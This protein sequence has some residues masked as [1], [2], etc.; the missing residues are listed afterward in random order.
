MNELQEA[1]YWMALA[2]LPN[3]RTERINT[4]ITDILHNR[5][6]TLADFFQCT[7]QEWQQEFL[8]NSK[9]A[10]DLSE[11]KSNIPQL[12][13]LAEELFKKEF[14]LIPI[15]ARNYSE[16]LKHNLKLKYAPPL[17][18]VKGDPHV[19]QEPSAAIVG[20]RNASDVSLQ[21]TD[22]I[23][24]RCVENYQ[25]VVSGFA[26]GVDRTALESALKY[27]GKS[28]LVLPQGIL[29][30]T[31]GFKRY[32]EQILAGDVLVLS[33]FLPK[34]PW[35]VKFAMARNRYIYGLAEDIY[36]AESDSTGGTWSGAIDG[37]KK[38]RRVYVRKPGEKERNANNLL[39]QKGAISVDFEGNSLSSA[40][41]QPT[42]TKERTSDD[43]M[44]ETVEA[45]I[46][47]AL[48]RAS[49]PL[50]AKQ[51][52]DKLHL[53]VDT[54]KFSQ[55]LKNMEGITVVKQNNGLTFR[56]KSN[57]GLQEELF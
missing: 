43:K 18:Y 39:I 14:V 13:S 5:G 19:L 7:E 28:I 36:V 34:I 11:A 2:H 37:L 22:N 1:A 8:L 31:S 44:P 9:E 40:S 46:K 52:K 48:S 27:N 26:K 6:L 29:K 35:D 23:A 38:G 16:T 42:K 47:Q 50:S 24:K 21:F 56:L 12:L 57:T 45:Q 25:V 53:E 10:S 51:I 33:T 49:K 17:L 15:N 55:Q 41:V 54:K 32:A 30:F 4:L 3:W 20:S